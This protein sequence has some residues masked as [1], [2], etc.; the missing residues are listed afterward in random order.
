MSKVVSTLITVVIAVGGSAVIWIGANL[1]F[2]QVRE[3]WDRFNAIVYG[4][5]GFVIGAIISGNRLIE[6]S[7]EGDNALAEFGS[8][9]WFPIVAAAAT[10]VLGLLLAKNDDP[11]RRIAIG[12]GGF[13]GL[14]LVVG[15]LLRA[16]NR[17]EVSIGGLV[18]WIAIFGGLGVGAS[19]LRGKPPIGGGL[20]GGALGWV[21]G[22]FGQPDLGDGNVG[23][24]IV[25]AVVPAALIGLRLAMHTNPNLQRRGL[26]DQRSRGVIF[27]APALLFIF[28]TLVVPAIRTIYLSFLDDKGEEGVGFDN[29]EATFTDPVSWDTSNW[30]NMFTSWPFLIGVGLLAIFA[31]LG[32]RGRQLTGKVVELGSPSM[33]PLVLGGLFVAFGA[34]TALRGTIINNLWWVIV[35]TSFSTGLGLAVAVLADNAKFE[36]VAKSII[37]MPMAISLVGASVIWRFMYVARDTSKEQT[38]VMN[39][40][41]VGI[42]RLSTGQDVQATA[43]SALVI[44]GGLVAVV[45]YASDREWPRAAIA[46]VATPV[47]VILLNVVWNGLSDDAVR[48]VVG[49]L[50]TL[51]FVGALTLVARAFVS[52]NYGRALMPG[53]VAVLLGW[54]LIRYWAIVGTGVGGHRVDEET[55]EVIGGQAINFVQDGPYNNFWLMVVLIWIQTGFSMVI[56]SAAIKAVPDELLEAAR[57]DGA[58]PSQIFW[59]VTL[60]QIGTTIGV[61]VTTLIVLVM[62]VY[63]I[64]KVMTNGNF[65]SQVLANDMFQQAFQ[66]NNIGRGASLAVLILVSVLPVMVFNIRRMQREI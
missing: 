57:V 25:A 45:H 15:L 32:T 53:V 7:G 17:P 11:T 42:G 9:V 48:V 37:F 18:I 30:T 51:A 54:F 36:R 35:V 60:P 20:V 61:V 13:G 27:L 1:V 29:Y 49:L 33:G 59:R 63:D 21:I 8:W 52:Q 10:A 44:I 40:L 62:K 5:A 26:I 46:L 3:H 41:W 39:A 23:W 22:A 12:V 31:Y 34:F 55:G 4:A 47:A 24:A 66:F 64:V 6:G 58:T 65:G 56:L 50:I 19:L 28:A 2:N 14:G 38:G 43:L 16:E